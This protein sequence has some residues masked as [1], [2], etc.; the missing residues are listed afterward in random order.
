M[1]LLE[2]PLAALGAVACWAV[3]AELRGHSG[4]LWAALAVL[5]QKAF[6][7]QAVLHFSSIAH[8]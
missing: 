2:E 1:L 8:Q 4:Q 6:S 5:S 7:A 3:S